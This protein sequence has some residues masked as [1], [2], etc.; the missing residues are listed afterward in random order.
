MFPFGGKLAKA[1]SRGFK[2]V[3]F[4]ASVSVGC[5]LELCVESEL[6]SKENCSGL[7]IRISLAGGVMVNNDKLHGSARKTGPV[8]ER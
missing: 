4:S 5:C 1:W 8:R 3:L 2:Y 6:H 7:V